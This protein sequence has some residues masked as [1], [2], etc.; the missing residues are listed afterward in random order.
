MRGLNFTKHTGVSKISCL[1]LVSKIFCYMP[2]EKL[3]S[4][5][6]NTSICYA[7]RITAVV[8]KSK[9]PEKKLKWEKYLIYKVV[10]TTAESTETAATLRSL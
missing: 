9:K 3:D 10:P 1:F 6:A 4:A 7:C 8:A 5:K 2:V